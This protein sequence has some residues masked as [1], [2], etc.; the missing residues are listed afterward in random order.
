MRGARAYADRRGYFPGRYAPARGYGAAGYAAHARPTAGGFPADL[1]ALNA[2]FAT[3]SATFSHAW[4]FEEASGNAVDYASTGAIPLVPQGTAPT[5]GVTTGLPGGDKGVQ[6]GD[7]S[8]SR[9][10]AA[11]TGDL[12]VTT[13]DFWMLGTTRL[14]LPT[15][16]R[17]LFAKYSG[18]VYYRVLTTGTG[19]IQFG[20]SDGTAATT[21]T[22]AAD[23]SGT[24]YFDWL[25]ARAAF[26]ACLI[27]DRADGGAVATA[28]ASLSNT[29]KAAV[30]RN[31]G[32]ASSIHTFLAWG[33]A[34]GSVLANRAAALAAWRAA[35]GA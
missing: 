27:T 35:R 20:L 26:Q 15:S 5:Q 33:T 10:E 3:W 4:N 28:T 30:G 12:D 18:T 9:M 25:V 22:A 2:I 29:G 19:Q 13:G 34:P 1:T 21:I 24:F 8:T 16:G 23:H 17:A 6:F 11:G 7:N 14:L 32:T 31:F